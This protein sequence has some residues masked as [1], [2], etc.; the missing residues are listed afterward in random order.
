MSN[1]IWLSSPHMSKEG[2]EQE[3]VKEAFETNWLAPQGPNINA[4]EKELA[5]RVKSKHAVALSSGTA[6][7]H[8]ALIAAGVGSG[9]IVLC[10]DL[11]FCATANPIV[12]LNAIPVFIDSDA[13]T[14]NMDPNVLEET[15]KKYGKR[16]KAVLPVHIYGLC[17]AMDEINDICKLQGITVIEDAA[18]SLGSTYDGKQT[19]TIGDYG[20]YSFNGNKIITTSGGGMLVSNYEERI[21]KV[22]FWSEQSQDDA[23]YYQHSEIGYNYRMSNISAGVGRGQ[24]KVLDRRIEKKRYIYN[25]YL[26]QLNDLEDVKPM[27]ECIKCKP[28]YWLSVF[29]FNGK[30]RPEQVMNALLSENIE[31][32]YVWKPMHLQPV[33][34][35]CDFWGGDVSE[36]LFRNGL[37]LPSDTKMT[38]SDLDRVC[39]IIKRLR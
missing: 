10:Q 16:I 15:V 7:L 4:F 24:L 6:A 21:N 19:G 11:T 34:A 17:A 2:F 20:I 27:P 23:P 22:R 25:Y 3:Y 29:Q 1:K 32:R 28:N 5:N 37:C 36:K 31:A 38:D 30:I 14:W 9:D 18:E 12:Y 13:K 26:K 8:M 35:D 33:F 39:S